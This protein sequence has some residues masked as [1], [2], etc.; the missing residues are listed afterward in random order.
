MS[1]KKVCP[2]IIR[3]KIPGKEI[4]VFRHP[5]GDVQFVKGN[6]KTGE[7]SKVAA[8]RELKEESGIENIKSAKLIGAWNTKSRKQVWYFYRC[9]TVEDLGDTWD[10]FTKDGGGQTFSFF[11]FDL[12][13]SPGEDW[14]PVFKRALKYIKRNI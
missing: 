4:L 5:N 11:W 10:F 9:K 14:L 3:K 6:I 8:L 1:V 2:V 7:K 13:D 12:A